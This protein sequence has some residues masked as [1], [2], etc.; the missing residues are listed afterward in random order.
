MLHVSH[1][2]EGG[3]VMVISFFLYVF[4]EVV[5]F[6]FCVVSDVLFM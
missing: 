6:V 4:S 1:V 3:V 5:L 2:F